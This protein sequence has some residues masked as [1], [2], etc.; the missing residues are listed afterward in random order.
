MVE[1]APAIA[2]QYFNEAQ[3][4]TA[5]GSKQA[6]ALMALA[7]IVDAEKVNSEVLTVEGGRG[8]STFYG[9][10]MLQAMAKA[11]DYE[12]AMQIIR[13]FWG[14]MLDMGATS[15][16]ED[17][18]LDWLPNAAPIDEL[19]P[20][21][22]KD[23]HGDFGAYCYE[24]FRHSLCHGWASGPTA[25]MIEHVLGVEVVETGGKVVRITPHLGNLQ[26]AKGSF[27]TPY[28]DIQISHTRQADGSVKSKIDAPRGVKIIK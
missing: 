10:Y 6:A 12:G 16:W 20:E 13:D 8:F 23:I 24:G 4:P 3:H 22:K 9:Y 18:N 14:G 2:E 19:V 21:G 5:P 11:G 17:F 15:F 1:A 28:G 7:G 27:P 25:W 26:W